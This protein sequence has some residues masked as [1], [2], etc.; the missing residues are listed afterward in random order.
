M[1]QCAGHLG[2]PAWALGQPLLTLALGPP[3]AAHV[4]TQSPHAGEGAF[5]A[6]PLRLSVCEKPISQMRKQ[7]MRRQAGQ[8]QREDRLR[9][10]PLLRQETKGSSDHSF[11]WETGWGQGTG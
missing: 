9:L 2:G 8:W 3:R 6:R 10:S 5:P 1:A 11:A 7:K 4:P